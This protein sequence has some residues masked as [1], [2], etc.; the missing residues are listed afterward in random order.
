MYV[1][2]VKKMALHS[3]TAGV[4][5]SQATDL[6]PGRSITREPL[7]VNVVWGILEDPYT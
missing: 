5:K 3:V 1:V 6:G 4:N 2:F 7:N